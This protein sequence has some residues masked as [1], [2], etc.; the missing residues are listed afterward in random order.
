MDPVTQRLS[1]ET[2]GHGLLDYDTTACHLE[3]HRQH[4]YQGLTWSRCK[5]CFVSGASV[6]ASGK[7]FKCSRRLSAFPQLA[8][9][10]QSGHRKGGAGRNGGH[11]LMPSLLYLVSP[12]CLQPCHV[13]NVVITFLRLLRPIRLS[14]QS[15]SPV[16]SGL[17]K[18]PPC[19]V[20]S[21]LFSYMI[22]H[23][24]SH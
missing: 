7:N 2:V 22:S 23:G 16:S 6:G 5:H 15:T 14:L 24:R 8:A 18:L 19:I 9:T 12:C 17:T 1:Q 20:F 21:F 3:K 4:A 13:S 10:H 11:Q